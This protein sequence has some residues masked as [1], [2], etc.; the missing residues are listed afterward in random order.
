MNVLSLF[1]G[2]GG[3]DLGFERVGMNVVGMCEIDKHAQKILQRH[4]SDATLHTDVQEVH[5]ER[6][7]VDLICG[8]F[9]C[10]DL[11]VAGKRR[12]LAGERSGLWHEFARII[13]E[14]EPAWV[15]IENVPGLFSSNAGRDFAV[16]ID[17]LAQRGYGVGWRVL[18][19]QGF[20]LAQRRKRVFIVASFGSPS[21][22]TVLLEPESVRRDSTASRK[23]G[24]GDTRTTEDSV[25]GNIAHRSVA[26]A[27]T[28]VGRRPEI[29]GNF[30]CA[31][32]QNSRDEV[33]LMQGNGSIVGALSAQLGMKQQNYLAYQSISQTLRAEAKQ[34]LMT[35]DGNINAPLA[36]AIN[37]QHG[38]WS[39]L[40]EQSHT[41]ST[42]KV[43]QVL[44]GAIGVRRLTPTECERLQGFPDGW[45]AGQADSNRYKQLGNAVAVPVAEWIGRRIMGVQ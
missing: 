41:L 1:S 9:P 24:Q 19:A 27:L 7:A 29:G 31:F 22:C 25:D 18:D 14:T 35:G 28:A 44:Q 39:E 37:G 43:E 2:I 23:A 42:T 15:V 5:Y 30:V 32:Q 33:R 3:F 11:S 12:G 20:G 26:S 6:G 16:I 17:W 38:Q 10:Q 45:T 8:G 34:S 21:G 36:I 13:D 4:F 40:Y